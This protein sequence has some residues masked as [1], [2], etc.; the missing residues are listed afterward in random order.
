MQKFAE[1]LKFYLK[2]HDIPYKRAAILCELDRTLLRRYAEGVR[3]P[4]DIQTAVRIAESLSMTKEDK[5]NLCLAYKRSKMGERQYYMNTVLNQI[6]EDPFSFT[7]KADSYPIDFDFKMPK[8]K[9]ET[10]KNLNSK[11]EILEYFFYILKETEHIMTSMNPI[12]LGLLK[13]LWNTLQEN[14]NSKVEHIIGLSSFYDKDNIEDVTGFEFIFPLLFAGNNYKIY[15]HYRWNGIS[16]AEK[17]SLNLVLTTKGMVL[18]D[19]EMS[20]GLFSNQEQYLLYYGQMFQCLK[21]NCNI[22]A[23]SYLTPE[24]YYAAETD[25]LEH[26]V[27]KMSLA[28]Q[29]IPKESIQIRKNTKPVKEICI[30]E[31]GMVHMAK[32]YIRQKIKPDVY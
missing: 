11:Q 15:H 18:F 16:K 28:F 22:F 31:E 29:T 13:L 7:H 27:T 2:S 21:Q 12:Y 24:K 19:F 9:K 32:I 25:F 3:M 30:E 20:Y 10:A 8:V 17:S 6:L 4:K 1:Y 5:D 26:P 14:P 23:R